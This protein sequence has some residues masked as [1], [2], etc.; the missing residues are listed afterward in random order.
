MYTLY[1]K[2]TCPFCQKVTSFAEGEGILLE[3][4]DVTEPGKVEEL[5]QIGG[6]KMVPFLVDADNEVMMYESGDIIACME[7]NNKQSS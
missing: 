4:I 6:K 5:I 1:Y 2:P 7:K 3:L